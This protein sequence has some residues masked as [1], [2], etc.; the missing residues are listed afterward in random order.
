MIY[1]SNDILKEGISNTKGTTTSYPY[2]NENGVVFV[3][4]LM[5]ILYAQSAYGT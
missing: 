1:P 2:T 5:L 4:V 3:V